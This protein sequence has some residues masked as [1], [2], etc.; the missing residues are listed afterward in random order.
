MPKIEKQPNFSLKKFYWK[1][2]LIVFL[3]T[4]MYALGVT[5]FI[6][7]HHFV[8]GGLTG[9]AVLVNYAIGWPVSIMV[10]VMN[11]LLLLVAFK[12]L[13]TEFLIKTIVGS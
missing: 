8:M 2:Y 4:F 13:G 12:I 9:I 7:P 10:F 1:D 11:A 3:G 5:Q 6:M